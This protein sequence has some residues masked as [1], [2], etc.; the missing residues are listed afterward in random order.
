LINFN[1][2]KDW[3]GKVLDFGGRIGERT[4]LLKNVIVAE[5]DES[6]IKFMKNNDIRCIDLKKEN[7]L[8]SKLQN[9]QLIYA[10][11]I[12]EHLKNPLKQLKRFH[13]ILNDNGTLILVLPSEF[14]IMR[15]QIKEV[16][17][18]GDEH[19]FNWNLTEIKNLLKEANFKVSYT[20]FN[21][22]HIRA[23]LKFAFIR[24]NIYWKLL[25]ILIN[26]FRWLI[27]ILFYQLTSKAKLSSCGEIIIYAKKV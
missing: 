26:T 4:S 6:A 3:N 10:S 17:G 7:G 16:D 27:N 18:G 13:N 21:P 25:W 5:I 8:Y 19:L 14:P 9:S 22:I 20:K 15:P 2:K 23:S 12:L 24:N 1:G 11:H